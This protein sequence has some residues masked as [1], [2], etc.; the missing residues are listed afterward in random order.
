MLARLEL[1]EARHA[2]LVDRLSETVVD[3]VT[4]LVPD[5]DVDKC[6]GKYDSDRDCGRGHKHQPDAKAHDSRKAYP[7][8]RTVWISRGAPPASV[9]FR[10]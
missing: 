4:E 2:N 9:F 1:R 7:T 5:Q 10:R 8:P 3:L 6:R